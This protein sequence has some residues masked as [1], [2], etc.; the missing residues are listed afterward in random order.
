MELVKDKET[1]EPLNGDKVFG[2]NERDDQ[3]GYPECYLWRIRQYVQ[4]H[5][6]ADNPESLL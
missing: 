2:L 6:S 3:Q 4:I 1:R 5:A